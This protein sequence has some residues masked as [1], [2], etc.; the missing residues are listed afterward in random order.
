MGINTINRTLSFNVSKTDEEMVANL[1]GQQF[2]KPAIAIFPFACHDN[3]KSLSIASAY[4][5]LTALPKEYKL[6]LIGGPAEQGRLQELNS[7]F[8]NRC[9]VVNNLKFAQLAAFLK[10]MKLFIAIDSGPL[11]LGRA[12]GVRTVALFG[13][14]DANCWG[15]NEVGNIT[16]A[17]SCQYSPCNGNRPNIPTCEHNWCMEQAVELLIEQH[18]PQIFRERVERWRE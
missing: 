7:Q 12:V 13:P 4:K 17:T 16:I 10:Q 8:D 9:Q 1:Y 18:L 6:F 3:K 14:S 5:L 11:H 2:N 15:T